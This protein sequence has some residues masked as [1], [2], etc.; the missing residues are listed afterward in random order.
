MTH[1]EKNSSNA[2][3][4]YSFW[5]RSL[6]FLIWFLVVWLVLIT[7][8]MGVLSSERGTQFILDEI[9]QRTNIKIH[10]VSGDFLT[11]L[12]LSDV[13]VP[14]TKDLIIK[15]NKLDLRREIGRASCR[16]RV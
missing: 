3:P 6:R 14:A 8:I 11:R 7:S 9:S 5:R 13:V 16:E 4:R 2:K 1:I 15:A 10:Y 12:S